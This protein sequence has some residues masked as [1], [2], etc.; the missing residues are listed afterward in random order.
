MP[1]AIGF[2]GVHAPDEL[3]LVEIKAEDAVKAGAGQMQHATINEYLVAVFQ[4]AIPKGTQLPELLV[5]DEQLVA[6]S[7]I[8]LVVM[9]RDAA[10]STVPATPGPVDI[11][12]IPVE[13]LMHTLCCRIDQID[14]A[15]ALALFAAANN[16][17]CDQRGNITNRRDW[18][19]RIYERI[20]CRQ[21]LRER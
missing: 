11:R 14:A 2:S 15:M 4:E 18:C 9:E 8:H 16:R 3:L 6:R 17:R 10:K 19:V 7:D 5:V 21:P 1:D 13:K 12:G 20:P